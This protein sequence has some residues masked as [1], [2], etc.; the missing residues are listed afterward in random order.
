MH[1]NIAKKRQKQADKKDEKSAEELF[2][3]SLAAE[4][5]ELLEYERCMAKNEL[6]NVIFKY[7]MMVL[8]RQHQVPNYTERQD[9]CECL[10][11]GLTSQQS[12]T[13]ISSPPSTPIWTP[14]YRENTQ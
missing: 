9:S 12:H 13:H 6:R 3:C 11:S 1:E 8:N 2:C 10:M 7:Q 14:Q 4:L 5:K